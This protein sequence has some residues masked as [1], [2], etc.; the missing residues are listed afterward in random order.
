M[1]TTTMR[2]ICTVVGSKAST[3][4]LEY[5]LSGM[6]HSTDNF[7]T[8]HQRPIH[9]DSIRTVSQSGH[10]LPKLA[11]VLQGPIITDHEFTF[12]TLKLYRKHYPYAIIILSTW[13]D[14]EISAITKSGNLDIDIVLN[15]KP[16]YP[17][18]SNINL[19][20]VSTR[21]GMKRAKA[22]GAEYVM[23]TRTD[24]RMYAPNVDQYLFNIINVFPLNDISEKQKRR[25]VG[26][27]LNTFKYRMYGLS[28]MFLYG[29]IDDL[30]LFWDIP[31][32]NRIFSNKDRDTARQSLRNYAQWRVSEVYLTTEYLFKV[33]RNLVWTIEDSWNAFAD[34]FCVVDKESL[35]I[36]WLKYTLKENRW[37]RY[38]KTMDSYE[39]VNFND[40]LNLNINYKQ[41]SAPPHVLD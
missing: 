36:F 33:D 37:R 17:G 26:V 28:D 5:L 18:E 29:H 40:W 6:Q 41:L 9:A 34:H 21:A 10:N 39:E 19:Q 31:L 2:L 8:Y 14:E 13:N 1:I 27:S 35:D 12:E 24:Q 20:I 15:Q 7:I 25:I 3:T 30:L 22:L 32:D 38:D 23:K 11:I 16:N 4:F